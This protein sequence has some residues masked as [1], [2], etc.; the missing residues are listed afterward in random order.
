MTMTTATLGLIE[1]YSKNRNDDDD[2]ANELGRKAKI[3]GVAMYDS[4]KDI[5][6]WMPKPNR[7][8]NLISELGDRFAQNFEQ[9][10]ITESM[11]FLRRA[12]AFYWATKNGQLKQKPIAAPKLYSEDLW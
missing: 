9:G 8:H 6:Y 12:P 1:N 4:D 10:F 2:Q 3:I 7:H 11:L 5:V